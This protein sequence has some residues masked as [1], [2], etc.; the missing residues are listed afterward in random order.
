MGGDEVRD[1][2]RQHPRL[3]A[4]RGAEGVGHLGLGGNRCSI[5]LVAK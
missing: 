2:R 4:R 1:A 3:Q 5:I